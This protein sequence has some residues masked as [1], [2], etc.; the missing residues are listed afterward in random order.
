MFNKYVIISN[1]PDMHAIC[2]WKTDRYISDNY[3]SN[4][5]KPLLHWALHLDYLNHSLKILRYFVTF[6]DALLSI[7]RKRL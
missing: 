5:S 3:G 4:P 6:Q 1:L 2:D 7:Q